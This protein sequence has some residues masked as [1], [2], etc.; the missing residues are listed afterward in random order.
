[1]EKRK[2]K[3][4]KWIVAIVLIAIIVIVLGLYLNAFSIPTG[5]IAG[6]TP[7]EETKKEAPEFTITG[8]E[9]I[10][11]ETTET[12]PYYESVYLESGRYTFD[13]RADVPVWV[14]VYSEERFNQWMEGEYTFTRTGTACCKEKYKV[15]SLTLQTLI[16]LKKKAANII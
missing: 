7:T 15:K 6:E 11:K 12:L 10:S 16:S 13:F 3:S 1:M 5:L 8:N 9:I 4:K 14:F 2:T